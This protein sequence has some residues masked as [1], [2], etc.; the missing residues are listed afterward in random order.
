MKKKNNK[1]F[2]LVELLIGISILAV[3]VTPLIHTFV[4]SAKTT[5]RAKEIR[6]QTLAAQ[7]V[8]ETYE[9]TNLVNLITDINN[10][11]ELT[12]FDNI[13]L[14]STLYAFNET[15]YE[16]VTAGA[17]YAGDGAGYKIEL[18]GIKA[19]NTYY[20]A[21]VH[22]DNSEYIQQ[23]SAEIVNY[24]S[25]DAVYIQP[26]PNLED[27]SNN[28]DIQAAKTFASQASIDTGEMVPASTFQSSMIRNIT[29]TIQKLS[30]ESATSVISCTTR[31]HYETDYTYTVM[32]TSVDPAEPRLIETRYITDINNDFF[33]G[34]AESLDGLYFFY[35]PN[36]NQAPGSETIEII[37]RNNVTLSIYLIRQSTDSGLYN[38]TINLREEY[39]SAGAPQHAQLN[40]DRSNYSYKYYTGHLLGSTYNDFWYSTK[41]FNGVLVDTTMQNR[42][43]SVSIELYKAGSGF[44]GTP[45][46]TFDAS[47][48]E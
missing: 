26:D 41:Y 46:M 11:E 48:I 33:S 3:V 35:Y 32:D 44:S 5:S 30:P 20:D 12:V 1:G 24:K 16:E 36:T 27:S 45:L 29:I 6:N 47:S 28:P 23:N 31:F 18:T 34:S 25:M 42:L 15:D 43:Y 2:S 19:N 10:N 38:P 13:A 4:T 39:V 9:A 17:Q 37:N 22:I 14:T 8:L 7:N 21:V 40:Y